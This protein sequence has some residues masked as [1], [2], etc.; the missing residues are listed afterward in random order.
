MISDP[1]P[2]AIR[3]GDFSSDQLNVIPKQEVAMRLL[4]IAALM[5]MLSGIVKEKL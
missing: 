3:G 4:L 5:F 2:I 1:A